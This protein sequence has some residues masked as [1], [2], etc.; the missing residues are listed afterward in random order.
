MIQMQMM[1]KKTTSTK[2]DGEFDVVAS[3]PADARSV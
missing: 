1:A 3:T 2:M